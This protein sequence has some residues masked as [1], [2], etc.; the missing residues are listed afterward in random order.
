M[1]L[2][3]IAKPVFAIP[4]GIFAAAYQV[5]LE[6]LY[7]AEDDDSDDEEGSVSHI[8]PKADMRDSKQVL[9][10]MTRE[11]KVEKKIRKETQ[12]RNSEI[13]LRHR[14]MPE[15]SSYGKSCFDFLFKTFHTG[16]RRFAKYYRKAFTHILLPLGILIA[17]YYTTHHWAACN[18]VL[19]LE[20]WRAKLF[21]VAATQEIGT[22]YS[23]EVRGFSWTYDPADPNEGENEFTREIRAIR[24]NY[25][26]TFP[27]DDADNPGFA[28]ALQIIEHEGAKKWQFVGVMPTAQED[29]D[30]AAGAS[31]VQKVAGA[32][33]DAAGAVGEEE[34]AAAGKKDDAVVPSKKNDDF[35]E[36]EIPIPTVF[37]PE[38]LLPE[39]NRPHT[40][41]F[42]NRYL[43]QNFSPDPSMAFVHC[44]GEDFG[45]YLPQWDFVEQKKRVF[46]ASAENDFEKGNEEICARVFGTGTGGDWDREEEWEA[47]PMQEE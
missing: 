29:G 44:K 47:H 34:V 13:A 23:M 17:A 42:L 40:L 5:Y 32:G 25:D 20:N 22:V 8:G 1:F 35:D 24:E 3:I 11:S 36:S 6:K 31:F 2:N 19:D 15:P 38:R 16:A 33:D 46:D 12:K 41:A 26:Q 45:V 4:G 10:V 30:D 43:I 39:E 21:E 18:G 14:L 9:G 7:F 28:L 27:I 37:R